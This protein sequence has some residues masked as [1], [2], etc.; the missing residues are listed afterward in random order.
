MIFVP[1]CDHDIFVSYSH[2]DDAELPGMSM[3]WV[4]TFVDFLKKRMNMKLRHDAYSLW[5]DADLGAYA[6]VSDQLVEAVANTAVLLVIVSPSYI[7]S[8]WCDRE[9]STFLQLAR[10]RGP[11]RVVV[12]Q[13]E[14]V[15]NMPPELADLKNHKFWVQEERKPLTR[16][17]FPV[18][19][20][21][22]FARMEDLC[23]DLVDLLKRLRKERQQPPGYGLH[24]PETVRTRPLV[25]LAW[26]N[27]DIELQRN[28]VRR[29]LEQ[30]GIGVLPQNSYDL[31]PDT[32]RTYAEGDMQK[33]TLFVQLLSLAPFRKPATSP[34]DWSEIQLDLARKL[35]KP[36]LQWRH[37]DLDTEAADERQKKLL[38]GAEVRAESIEDFKQEVKKQALAKPVNPP[39]PL[40]AFV[41]V[42][43][44]LLD[45][46]LA[47]EVCKSLNRLGANYVLP[48]SL[49]PKGKDLDPAVVHYDLKYNLENCD[50]LI[51]LYGKSDVEWVRQQIT[52]CHKALAS[53]KRP[54]NALAVF[55]G[56]PEEKE[57]LNIFL[58]GM[59]VV[60]CRS[61]TTESEL[62]QFLNAV[63]AEN[64][65]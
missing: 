54:L 30:A 29:F 7:T 11:T 27:Y 44:D 52:Q 9:R 61:G 5:T 18:P 59:R 38:E 35:D 31:K 60:D 3:G 15:E 22:Y 17:G 46:P 26:T 40:N 49:S 21:E 2:D 37:P 25:Y 64:G 20:N 13:C 58:Q 16:L 4:T 39:H 53:R 19:E 10:D 63:R 45:Q 50:A 12:V 34:D 8:E 1:D 36:R 47:D 62:Q 23:G 55:E 32:F 24:V 56:P 14:P 57:P 51:V 28:D 33:C 65:K 48:R 42:D 6:R 41:F 43:T